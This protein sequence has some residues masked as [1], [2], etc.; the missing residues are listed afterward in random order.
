MRRFIPQFEPPALIALLAIGFL[1]VLISTWIAQGFTSPNWATLIEDL[2]FY[3]GLILGTLG[4]I[5]LTIVVIQLANRGSSYWVKPLVSGLKEWPF[6]LALCLSIFSLAVCIVLSHAI[7]GE[8]EIS[9]LNIMK[10][11]YEN[12]GGIFAVLT[13]LATLYGVG[14]TLQGLWELRRTIS[15]FSEL[16]DRVERMTQKATDKNPLHILAYTPAI[17]YLAQPESDWIRFS[18][19]LKKQ[20]TGQPIAK[21]TCLR[22]QDLKIWHRLFVGR[23]TLKGE[24][25]KLSADEATNAGQGLIDNLTKDNS[26]REVRKGVRRLPSSFMPGYYLFFTRERAIIVAP[27]FLPFPKGVPSMPEQ[28][29]TVQ[30]IGLETQD[31]AIIRDIEQMYYYYSNLPESLLGE[32]TAQLQCEAIKQWLENNK[33]NNNLSDDDNNISNEEK[34]SK[35][36]DNLTKIFSEDVTNQLRQELIE[37]FAETIIREHTE[38]NSE[39]L[40][41][42]SEYRYS[43]VLLQNKNAVIELNLEANLKTWPD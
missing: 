40:S 3:T 22:E 10:P 24:I 23:R 29:P 16:I 15:S 39:D 17:G 21:I 13:G 33:N 34:K 27:L 25:S 41:K 32:S 19:A 12:P 11:V 26:N 4:G 6:L 14:L 43:N 5:I 1:L 42:K 8:N 30:M 20:P 37:C 35:L 2:H 31:R 28:L 36:K 18:E 7:V 9:F 38:I